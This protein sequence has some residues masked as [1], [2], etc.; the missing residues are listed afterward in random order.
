LTPE[1]RRTI[2]FMVWVEITKRHGWYRKKST[3]LLIEKLFGKRKK[4]KN[5]VWFY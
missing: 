2:G 3:F 1:V 4:K 5:T